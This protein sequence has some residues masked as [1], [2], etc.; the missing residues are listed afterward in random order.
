MVGRIIFLPPDGS[1]ASHVRSS[2]A[3]KGPEQTDAP[4][5]PSTG[6]RLRFYPIHPLH[7]RHN[8]LSFKPFV[9]VT[10]VKALKT[11]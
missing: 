11:A 10:T 6:T 7:L 5:N 4:K 1:C 9:L 2:T 3:S 8:S